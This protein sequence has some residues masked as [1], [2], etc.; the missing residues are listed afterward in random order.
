LL[1]KTR[2]WLNEN[3]KNS[4]TLLENEEIIFSDLKENFIKVKKLLS[5]KIQGK[6]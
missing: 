1:Q 6:N 2:N 5:P 4:E 3:H